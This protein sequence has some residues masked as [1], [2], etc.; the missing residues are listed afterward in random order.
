MLSEEILGGTRYCAQNDPINHQIKG[1]SFRDFEDD[2]RHS[3]SDFSL[4]S[5]R[6]STFKHSLDAEIN[7]ED[8]ESKIFK[9]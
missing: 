7:L 4:L 3:R 8:K 6:N 9:D 1:F 2:H 5:P